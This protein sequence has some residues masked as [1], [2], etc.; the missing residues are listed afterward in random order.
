MKKS[1]IVCD[2]VTFGYTKD[3][4][5]LKQA[6]FE[7]E[8]GEF[9][10]V[11]GPNGG[12]KT[13]LLRLLMGFCTPW[14]G[15]IELFGQSTS[16]HPSGI[17]YV[18]QNLRFDKQFPITVLEVVLGGRLSSL[19]WFGTF[20]QYDKEC[21]L[22]ALEQV[23]LQEYAKKA[24]GTL[25]GGQM[26]RVLIARALAQKPSTLLLD[27]PTANVDIEAEEGLYELINE[28]K[29][30]HT[31]IMVTHDIRAIINNVKKILCVQG[32]VALIQPETL[33]EHF[34]MGLYHYPLIE[35]TK[36]HFKAETF[37]KNAFH[38]TSSFL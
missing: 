25:S 19:S 14:Q 2:N 17:A 18:P 37:V 10:A 27:E 4:P 38:N 22:H 3:L 5:V 13:T 7:I 9:I 8:E 28:L 29:G 6:S 23:G 31:I 32:R 26:Q 33:C 12:G 16:K 34:A 1:F 24:F 21:A 35:T 15:S 20:S 11:I 30:Q 36:S